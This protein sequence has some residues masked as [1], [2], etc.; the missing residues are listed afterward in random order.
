MSR[1]CRV[2]L[3][4]APA[5]LAA[6]ALETI[7]SSHDTLQDA[8]SERQ[9]EKGWIRGWVP[10]EAINIREVHNLDSNSSSLSFELPTK[11]ALT[12]PGNCSR[13]AIS[14]V[15][16]EK[17]ERSWWPSAEELSE[18]YAFHRCSVGAARLEFVGIR[19]DRK[20]VIHW[21]THAG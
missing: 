13:V 20:R 1:R 8:I 17:F 16:H 18:Q 19:H 12:I 3:L 9:V 7:D 6:C 21:R 10:P 14:V 15:V 4:V 5:L 11:A 2:F